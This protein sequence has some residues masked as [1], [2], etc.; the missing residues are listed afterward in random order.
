MSFS[1]ERYNELRELELADYHLK[2]ISDDSRGAG[3]YNAEE[4]IGIKPYYVTI[5]MKV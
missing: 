1:L 2:G 4:L 5:K 3:V